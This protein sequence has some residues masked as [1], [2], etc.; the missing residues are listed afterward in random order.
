MTERYRTKIMVEGGALKGVGI[1]DTHRGAWL[2]PDGSNPYVTSI[3]SKAE[4]HAARLNE[5][6]TRLNRDTRTPRA[7]YMAELDAEGFR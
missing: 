2:C 1:F 4:F 3:P 5:W 7:A 6:E